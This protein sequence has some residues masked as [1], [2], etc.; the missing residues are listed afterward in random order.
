MNI[1]IKKLQ[2]KKPI[3]VDVSSLF[4]KQFKGAPLEIK[5]AFRETIVL[6][7]ENR[8]HPHL[9]NHLLKDK[10]AGCRSMDITEDWRAIYREKQSGKERVIY[11]V[12]LGTHKQLYQPK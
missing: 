5:Q 12:A 4:E 7:L 6:F 2:M 9:R 1:S 3:R 10:Y 8:N 11:F